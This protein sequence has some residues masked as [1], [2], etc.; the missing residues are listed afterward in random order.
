MYRLYVSVIL[1]ILGVVLGIYAAEGG[2]RLDWP[3]T[4]LVVGIALVTAGVVNF[5]G[6]IGGIDDAGSLG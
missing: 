5:N 4:A 2:V 1:T 6:A 3:E